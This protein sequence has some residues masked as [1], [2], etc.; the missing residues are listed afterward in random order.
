[1]RTHGTPV[2]S[3]LLLLA[4]GYVLSAE[5]QPWPTTGDGMPPTPSEISSVLH[6]LKIDRFSVDDG[7]PHNNVTSVVQ[8]SLGFLWLGTWD[9]L[10]RYDGTTFKIYTRVPGDSTS[11]SHSRVGDL[12]E[13]R[14]GT[15]WVGTHGGGLNRFDPATETF[16][17]YRRDP[18]DPTSLSQDTVSVILEDRRGRMWVG[19]LGGGLNR[20]DPA[21]GTFTRYRH[22]PTDST[23]LSNDHVRV[24]YEDRSGALW[25]GTG[26][27]SIVE[28]PPGRGG[29]N[30]F[31][32]AAGIFTLYEHDPA[33][34]TSLIDNRVS[35]L[36][37]DASGRFWVGTLGNV[38]HVMDRE[39]GT[40]ERLVYDPKRPGSLHE[41]EDISLPSSCE[42]SSC[43]LITFLDE[44]RAGTLWIGTLREGL[45]RCDPVARVVRHHP[46][47]PHNP[48]GLAN[49]RTV[50]FAQS[51]D[52][53]IW[54]GN[55]G[56]DT[57]GLHR[58]LPVQSMPHYV[59]V[60]GNPNS[61]SHDSVW[62]LHADDDGVL[63]IATWGGGLNRLDLETGRFTQHRHDPHDPESLSSDSLRILYEDRQG[64]LWIG[65][66]D[67]VLNRFEKTS[68]RVTRYVLE[69]DDPQH[70]DAPAVDAVVRGAVTAI[71]EDRQGTLWV[72]TFGG[73][74]KR[75]DRASGIVTASYRH[76]GNDPQ[77][78]SSNQ[79]TA[80]L[81]DRHGSLW[82]GTPFG[83]NR[84]DPETETITRHSSASILHLFEDRAGRIW[85]GTHQDGLLRFDPRTD[86]RFA[87]AHALTGHAVA[88]IVEDESGRLWMSTFTGP[89]P[90][91]P[92]AGSLIRFDPMTGQDRVLDAADGMPDVAFHR[93]SVAVD[94]DG[95]LYLG[96]PDGF[97]TFDPDSIAERPPPRVLLT[98]LRLFNHRVVPGP[99]APVQTP[100]YS[101]E[102]IRLS[103]RQHDFTIDYAGLGFS[104]GGPLDYRYMLEHHDEDWVDARALRSARYSRLR[105]G[106]Y[107]FRVQAAR[108]GEG[109]SPEA[110]SI[111]VNVLPPW[112]RTWWAYLLYG[113]LLAGAF[114]SADRVQRRRIVRRERERAERQ[115]DALRAEAAEAWA[116][117]LQSE[118]ERQTQELEQARKVQLSML[119][120][121]M[122]EHPIIEV[123]A[124]METATEVGGDYYDFYVG[125]DD[126]L[127]LAI[128][129]ATGHG[130]QAGTMVTAMKGLF[131]DHAGE[132]DLLDILRR[133]T[134]A[135]RRM[136]LPKLYMALALARLRGHTLELA[137]AG[138]PP[139]LIHRASSGSIER[140]PLKG[141]PLGSPFELPYRAR[142]VDLS[143]G[144]TI[145]LMSDGFP[146]LRGDSGERLGYEQSVKVVAEAAGQP[147]EQVLAHLM[148]TARTWCNGTSPEDDITFIV[149]KVKDREIG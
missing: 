101:A 57:A 17:H 91:A 62:G 147:A 106:R 13:D 124:H 30:R 118:N 25:V 68:G 142:S 131:T 37:E 20:F 78:L 41:V 79:I 135:L 22:N 46:A 83:L 109:W 50:A 24:L 26:N 137:G 23:S 92:G 47:D 44:D 53:T 128:G 85:A 122:P 34:P 119:P 111:A 54:I 104:G 117:Y 141:L 112:W 116:N 72:G 86:V 76:E 48:N 4:F 98:D 12:H 82:V 8:D 10:V 75:F 129:D 27:P 81:E 90:V 144:D 105:P 87:T 143:Q 14:R 60:P 70:S 103:H 69:T 126:T 95:R 88:A 84:F 15:L 31:D 43:G 32:R 121:R 2:T 71:L 93:Q 113:L 6:D 110:A 139:A 148:K 99:H 61:L 120:E 59:N 51:R 19:T 80:I 63:W 55:L 36:Y 38:L 134:R 149:L 108:R 35:S 102:A 16:T 100:I 39:T 58:V 97:I 74:L 28:A 132:P 7:L 18:D 73:G 96:G 64:V 133:S 125:E 66:G 67:G 123:R 130:L 33:D 136:H 94:R 140:V 65:M 89:R 146:E 21:A 9:G 115:A 114:V 5:A 77:S 49:N 107:V 52:G 145:V 1:M 56:F 40:F 127:T 45:L 3:F 11:L 29:L 138:M 42:S